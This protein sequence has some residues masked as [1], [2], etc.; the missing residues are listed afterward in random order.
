MVHRNGFVMKARISRLLLWIF[1]VGCSIFILDRF[2]IHPIAPLDEAALAELGRKGD[3]LQ[4]Q[5]F[6]QQPKD[7]VE[8]KSQT[9]TG[10]DFI[11]PEGPQ[12]K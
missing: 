10:I 7:F 1:G 4:R 11:A 6:R 3:E 5:R 9:V 2:I 8:G 12:R